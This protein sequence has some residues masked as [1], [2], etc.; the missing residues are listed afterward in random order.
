[1][2]RNDNR[3][4]AHPGLV[5]DWVR[6]WHRQ[7]RRF[8][9]QRLASEADAQDLAQEVYLRL[10]RFESADLV[11]NPQ[12]YLCKMA[13]HVVSEWKQEARQR[14]P[15]SSQGLDVLPIEDDMDDTLDLQRRRES[16]GRALEQLPPNMRAALMLH[17]LDGLSYQ[18]IA[19][20]L[21][22]TLRMVRR[23]IEDGYVRLRQRMGATRRGARP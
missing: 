16:L 3:K 20:E 22:V 2:Q 18:Q 23:Y 7:L 14:M 4:P 15:H 11:R 6:Q 19:D 8:L 12:A 13:S 1:M 21:G 17:H 10:L 5:E 9:D